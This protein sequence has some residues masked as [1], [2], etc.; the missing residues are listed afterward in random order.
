MDRLDRIYDKIK[1]L[2]DKNKT[3][4]AENKSLSESLATIQAEYKRLAAESTK[5]KEEKEN[6]GNKLSFYTLAP[7]SLNK[8]GIKEKIDIYISEIDFCIKQLEKI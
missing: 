1:Q 7:E 6:L 5:L 8:K 3:L 4:Q 2:V